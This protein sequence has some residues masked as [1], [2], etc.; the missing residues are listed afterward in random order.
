LD[1]SF[2]RNVLED[3]RRLAE[4]VLAED[5]AIDITTEVTVAGDAAAE[6]FLEARSDG[7]LAGSAY[8]DAVAGGCALSPVQWRLKDG[9]GFRAGDQLGVLRGPLRAIL[10]C[11]RPLL[12]LLQRACGIATTTRAYV[13]A[14]KGT[15]CRVLHT[16]KT[17]PGLRT[18]DVSAVFAAGGSQHRLDLA[19]VVLVKD[20]HWRELEKSGLSLSSAREAALARGVRAFQVEVESVSQLDAACA[21]GATRILV[22]NQ[23]PQTVRQWAALARERA[24]EIEVEATG[25]VD[26]T[27]VREYAEA[28]ADF[29]SIGALTHSVRAVDIS[30]E[31][32]SGSV[33]GTR[34]A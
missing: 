2:A 21:A 24:P 9:D 27:N 22:D 10:R 26:L 4:T 19:S 20:N 14:L 18:F 29:V 28:G 5:G 3:A 30:L 7:V 8:A 32:I 25:G 12:N 23:T 33:P 6:A 15:S 1:S 31:V 16:R 13:D 34:P 17:A 11:E